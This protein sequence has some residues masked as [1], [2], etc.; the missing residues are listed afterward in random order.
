MVLA[1]AFLSALHGVN[2][3]VHRQPLAVRA[4]RT[5]V[6]QGDVVPLRCHVLVR[7]SDTA[8]TSKSGLSVVSKDKPQHGVVVAVGPGEAAGVD[9]V[10]TGQESART[11]RGGLDH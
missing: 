3:A 9:F 6:A 5:V 2:A 7:L 1:P 4:G 10:H 11:C 8:T